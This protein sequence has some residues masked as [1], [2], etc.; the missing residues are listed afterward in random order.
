[1]TPPT[2]SLEAALAKVPLRCTVCR[3]RAPDGP[4]SH[5]HTSFERRSDELADVA[6]ALGL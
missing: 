2:D 4:F 1:M 6:R 3:F 5:E